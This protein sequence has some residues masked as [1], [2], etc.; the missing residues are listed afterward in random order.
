MSHTT[1]TDQQHRLILRSIAHRVMLERGLLPDFSEAIQAELE[2]MRPEKGNGDGRRDLRNLLWA[3]IDNDNSQ[4]LDQLTAAEALPDGEV[5]IMV[6]VADVEA[7]V[8]K[9]CAVDV[10]AQHNTTSVYTTAEI[11][12]ML[13]EKL[14]TDMTSLAFDHDRRWW[15]KW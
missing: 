15:S 8:T 4:D 1:H 12:P 6:A 3:S 14:S 13:P 5:K 9:A 10:H 7:L 11:F 2:R